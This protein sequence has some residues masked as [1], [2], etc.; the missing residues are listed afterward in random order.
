VAVDPAAKP[1]LA[2]VEVERLELVE[3]DRLVEAPHRRIVAV[4]VPQ[5]VAGGEGVARV[6]ADADAR[7]VGDLVDDGGEFLEGA[8]EDGALAGGGLEEDH[9]LA[10]WLLL[11]DAVDRL[12]DAGDAGLWTGREG[13]AGVADEVGDAEQVAAGQ[14]VG[15]RRPRFLP[16]LVVGRGDVDQVG[17]VGD[18]ALHAATGPPRPERLGGGR[19][20]RRRLPLPLVLGEELEGAHLAGEGAVDGVGVA[21]GDGHVGAE[22]EHGWAT[23]GVNVRPRT[24]GT[25]PQPG[26]LEA[27]PSAT[28]WQSR[29]GTRSGRHRVVASPPLRPGAGRGAER[30][31]STRVSRPTQPSPPPSLSLVVPAYNEAGRIAATL[32]EATEFLAGQPFAT[33]LILVDDGSDDETARV[34]RAALAG[35]PNARVLA[36]PH[37]GKAAAV[38]AGMA[39]SRLEQVAFSDA[40][41]ATPL[42]ALHD[43][44]AALAAGCDVAIGSREGTGARRIGEPL[45]RHLMGRAFN[46]LVWALLLRGIPDTQC[47]FK[48]FRREAAR[49]IL[50]R[51][52]LYADGRR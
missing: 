39:E 31:P 37:G 52:R 51:S 10:V 5:L 40:D 46:G 2:V 1:F 27:H 48:L 18:E 12:G 29:A 28:P 3:T 6:E 14:L 49:A 25:I 36:I 45:Y 21:A 22:F 9:R 26:A 23:P 24:T 35:R 13:G 47:G 17:V 32:S 4:V 8:A 20:D 7:L 34:A 43:L 15:Q 19:V 44:R 41:L 30:E 38:R 33:E 16:H 50:A 11:V 42:A